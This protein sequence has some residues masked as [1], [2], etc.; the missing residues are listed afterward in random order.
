MKEVYFKKLR[1]EK[2]ENANDISSRKNSSII[3]K[4]CFAGNSN[5]KVK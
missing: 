5:K 1:R 2:F 4:S 3:N